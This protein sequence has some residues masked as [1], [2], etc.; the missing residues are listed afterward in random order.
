MPR[1]VLASWTSEAGSVVL[2]RRRGSEIFEPLNNLPYPQ[3]DLS[4]NV[5][6][7]FISNSPDLVTNPNVHQQV[8]R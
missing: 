2:R 1:T 3:R 6:S 5:H 7:S 4:E 8:N